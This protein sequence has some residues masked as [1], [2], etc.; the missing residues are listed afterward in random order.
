M[1]AAIV[2]AC[3]LS[4]TLLTRCKPITSNHPTS[5]HVDHTRQRRTE[6]TGIP[7][8][9]FDAL[10]IE[11]DGSD[12]EV[13][14]KTA[15]LVVRFS[16]A[17]AQGVHSLTDA[18]GRHSSPIRSHG[19]PDRRAWKDG[20]NHVI[21]G[22]THKQKFSLPKQRGFA[23][24]RISD[25]QQL[26]QHVIFIDAVILSTSRGTHLQLQPVNLGL[27]TIQRRRTLTQTMKRVLLLLLL[28]VLLLL[29]SSVSLLLRRGCR[30]WRVRISKSINHDTVLNIP[31]F[32]NR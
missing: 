19:V 22:R 14:N 16:E 10:A 18:D 21:R 7:D 12:F 8:L 29:L 30:R 1:R 17:N 13:C 23:H 15:P 20:S 31:S 32:S 4:K 6:R 25:D 24:T 5:R 3:D 28:P 26:D 2:T 9:Q 11:L 27:E